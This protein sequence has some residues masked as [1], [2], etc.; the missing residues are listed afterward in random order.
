MNEENQYQIKYMNLS[1]TAATFTIIDGTLP[2]GVILDTTTGK[3]YG[4]PT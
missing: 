2:I 4:N 1:E 3:L